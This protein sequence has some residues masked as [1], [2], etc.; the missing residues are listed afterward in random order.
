MTEQGKVIPLF[1]RYIP[2]LCPKCGQATRS[3]QAGMC[4][5]CVEAASKETK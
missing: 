3:F 2:D 5:R 1:K 4:P